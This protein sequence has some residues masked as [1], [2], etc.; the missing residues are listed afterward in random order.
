MEIVIIGGGP[1]A[2][3]ALAALVGADGQCQD[4]RG[5]V[6]VLDPGA[7]FMQ[8]WHARIAA[9]EIEYLRSPAF[10]HP[11]AFQPAALVN[12]AIRKGRTTELV[13]APVTDVKGWVPTTDLSTPLLK[14]LPSSALF[15]DFCDSLAATLPHRWLSGTA[16]RVSK[17]SSTGSYRVHYTT[18]GGTQERTVRAR[19][20]VLATGPVGT[21]NVPAP[22]EPHLAATPRIVH[23]EELLVEGRGTLREEIARAIAACSNAERGGRPARVLV[24]GGGISAAQAALAAVRAGHHVVLRSRRPLQT[25]AFDIPS[26]WLDVRHADRLRFEFLC[27]PMEKRRAAVR[28]AT[29]GGSV[30]ATHVAELIRLSQSAGSKLCLEVD[31]NIDRS[32]VQAGTDSVIV[33][34]ESFDMVVVATGVSTGPLDSDLHRSVQALFHAP[35]IDGLPLVHSCL[36]WVPGEE[37]FVLGANA[38]LELGPGAGNLVG[39]MRG[40]RIISNELHGLMTTRQQP[41]R[42]MLPG[43]CPARP[44]FQNKYAALLDGSEPEI[45]VLT[46]RLH[47]SPKAVLSLKTARERGKG[48]KPAK[49]QRGRCMVHGPRVHG[50]AIVF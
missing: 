49:G 44:V 35:T 19:A 18:A 31:E 40:S 34:G 30:P 28:A 50:R 37:L 43:T 16:T 38:A 20:V 48:G 47:L 25:R 15:K 5:A 42:R 39:A 41:E 7:Q 26:E 12:F 10:V 3:A 4:V 27:L 9:L 45:E 6:A 14:T 17:D 2:L 8:Q 22:F 21:W 24:V 33:N 13:D 11:V 29:T 23:T 36:R 1:H 46:R 32:D